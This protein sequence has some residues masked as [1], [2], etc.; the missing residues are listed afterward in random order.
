MEDSWHWVHLIDELPEK[1]ATVDE[2]MREHG[3][4]WEAY[5]DDQELIAEV[6]P[7]E[8]QLLWKGSD[9]TDKIDWAEF[10]ERL[11]NLDPDIWCN[12]YLV[13][14][15]EKSEAL[16]AGAEL[17]D[18]IAEIYQ[19]LLPLYMASTRDQHQEEEEQD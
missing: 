16:S 6:E 4:H 18:Q 7:G 9:G 13:G 3:L 11:D 17:G 2:A 19:D 1:H 15:M 10:A 12:L 5:T 14:E 8:E